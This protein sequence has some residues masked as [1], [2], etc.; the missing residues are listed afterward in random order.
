VRTGD[1]CAIRSGDCL[2]SGVESERTADSSG[3][4]LP[5]RLIELRTYALRRMPISGARPC[6]TALENEHL[7]AA[8]G[9]WQLDF[10]TG[11]WRGIFLADGMTA[12]GR[13]EVS[14]EVSFMVVQLD[15]QLYGTEFEVA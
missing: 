1:T 2:L 14:P 12:S 8:V 10:E 13:N 9:L 15:R 5:L 7:R 11:H 3:S 6:A 4:A